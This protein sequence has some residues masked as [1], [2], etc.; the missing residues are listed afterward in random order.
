MAFGLAG[1]MSHRSNSVESMSLPNGNERAFAPPPM[2]Y[3]RA[4]LSGLSCFLL[5]YL[6]AATGET[7]ERATLR[8]CRDP[9]LNLHARHR[10][11]AKRAGQFALVIYPCH[12]P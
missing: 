9:R 11:S 4:R 1:L 3:P 6:C 7:S 10:Q 8:E 12:C 5:D 2:K